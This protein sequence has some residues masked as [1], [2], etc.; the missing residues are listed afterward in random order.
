MLLPATL[1]AAAARFVPPRNWPAR[2]LPLDT[3][4]PLR[5]RVQLDDQRFD[6]DLRAPR[7]ELVDHRAQ[8][9]VNRIGRG[10]DQRVGGRVGLDHP[11]W[12]VVVTA[13]V[14]VAAEQA[15]AA[16]SAAGR[17]T[18]A[19][20]RRR[21]AAQAARRQRRGARRA[22]REVA[23]RRRTAVLVEAVR[24][25]GR[26]RRAA[27]V[28]AL[29]E[30]PAQ[31]LRELHRIG[32][33]QRHDV[34]VAGH[35]ARRVELQRE[36]F[37]GREA[38]PVR[39]AQQQRIGARVGR[40]RHLQR[41]VAVADRTRVEHLLHLR[42]E[43]D[44]VRVAQRHDLHLRARGAVD[45]RDDLRDAAHVVRI[46]GHDDRVVRRVGRHR[47]VRRDQRPQ[48]GQ[49]V[50]HRF[51]VQLEHLRDHLVATRL[52]R[53]ADVGRHALQLRVGFRHDLQHAVILHEREALHAQRRLQRLQRLVFRH[54]P[55][56]HEI[57]LPLH[58][59]VDDD[60]LAGRGADRFRDLVD[61][62]IHEIERD[63]SVG[64]LRDDDAGHEQ[65]R[66]NTPHNEAIS[67]HG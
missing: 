37:R 21:R 57:E 38:R 28:A 6:I 2:D 48:H 29:A 13:L 56:G 43:V 64:G 36:T 11:A 17:R 20:G 34:H 3:E 65:G 27:V 31:R 8:V 53:I 1:P 35:R 52:R 39:C 54:R 19:V 33:A 60:G 67:C 4:L 46:V 45:A 58:A 55:F 30:H 41:R 22:G 40:D 66:G 62:R 16:D 23:A 51:V 18:A 10:D 42:G 50:V 7:V 24:I 44:R 25:V 9:P 61:I 14:L 47:V 63:L 12:L 15:A 5:R 59:G 49:Q 32:V 26:R